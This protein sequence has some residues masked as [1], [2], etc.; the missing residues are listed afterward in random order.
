MLPVTI[1]PLGAHAIAGTIRQRMLLQLCAVMSLIVC[2]YC[3]YAHHCK[4]AKHLITFDWASMAQSMTNV[5]VIMQGNEV[6]YN[7]QTPNLA[8]GPGTGK[9]GAGGL[10]LNA[11]AGGGTPGSGATPTSAG[12]TGGLAPVGTK[13]RR[14]SGAFT[15]GAVTHP[16][17][18]AAAGKPTGL[19]GVVTPVGTPSTSHGARRGL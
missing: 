13:V 4:R 14:Q 15:S 1:S 10:T 2:D 7:P 19:E 16:A 11:T 12:Y 8:G 17:S 5:R 18:L 9:A 3:L 6:V